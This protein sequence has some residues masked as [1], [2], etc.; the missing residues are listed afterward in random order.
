MKIK[1][2]ISSTKNY[3]NLTLPPLIKSLINSSID[4]QDILIV[5]GGHNIRS[6]E[7]YNGVEYIKTNQNTFDWTALI[8]IVEYEIKSDFWFLIHDTCLVSN[9]FKKL[10]YNINPNDKKI[11]LRNDASMNIGTYSYTYLLQNKDFL[12]KEK[13]TK[14]DE[15]T[16][17]QVKKRCIQTEDELLRKRGAYSLYNPLLGDRQ[18]LKD[19]PSLHKTDITR[20]LEYYPQLDFYKSKANCGKALAF[21]G[22]ELITLQGKQS[23]IAL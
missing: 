17:Q 4:K 21:K 15:L 20:I 5:E 2:A 19:L 18:T 16:L 6:I 11:A 9:N 23:V 7:K 12:L 22:T 8:D 13:N 10:L 14:Y 3:S 1:I